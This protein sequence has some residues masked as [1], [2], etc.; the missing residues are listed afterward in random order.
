[1]G[2]DRISD[3]DGMGK[4]APILALALTLCLISLTG[5]PPTAGFMVKFYIFSSAVQH[6]L[7]WLVII[8]VLN[9][10]VSAYYYLRVVKVMW[11]NEPKFEGN[12]PSS[13]ALRTAL[14][15]SCAG[16]ILLGV[17]PNYVM[18]LAE[19]AAKMFAF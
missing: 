19:M 4:Q 11:L 18:K 10:V 12:V 7:L 14:V 6:G 8:A 15:I 17:L 1:V 3:Y 16:V 13:L 2:S 9:S 5:V